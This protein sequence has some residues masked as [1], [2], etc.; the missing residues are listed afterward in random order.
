[1]IVKQTKDHK[2]IQ[3]GICGEIREIL[4]GNDY[5]FDI[6]LAINID[7][8]TAHYQKGFPPLVSD[9]IAYLI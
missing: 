3:T 4:S 7:E 2:V 5:S 6:A 8:T 9:Y 1:M